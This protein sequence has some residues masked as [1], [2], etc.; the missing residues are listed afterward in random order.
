MNFKT[1]LLK[2]EIKKGELYL[3]FFKCINYKE[4]NIKQTAI[5]VPFGNIDLTNHGTQ[6]NIRSFV[7]T[8]A[9]QFA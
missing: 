9:S 5:H 6:R 8:E 7:R 4:K 1:N 3:Y 2:L